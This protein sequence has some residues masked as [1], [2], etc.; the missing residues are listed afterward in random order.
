MNKPANPSINQTHL[1]LLFLLPFLFQV[2]ISKAQV[3]ASPTLRDGSEAV[4]DLTKTLQPNQVNYL[5]KRI[6]SL[7]AL[8]GSRIFI[9]MIYSTNRETLESYS[10]NLANDL[11]R[12]MEQPGNAVLILVAK[13]DRTMRI[14]VGKSLRWGLSN[15]KAKSIIDDQMAPP[16]KI[17]GYFVGINQGLSEVIGVLKSHKGKQANSWMFVLFLPLF[18]VLEVLKRF[19]SRRGLLVLVGTLAY[20]GLGWYLINMTIGLAIMLFG[21]VIS[22][23]AFKFP[24][25]RLVPK[26]I[27]KQESTVGQQAVVVLGF[28]GLMFTK[29][30]IGSGQ[31]WFG[32][33]SG[34]SGGGWGGDAGSG[35]SGGSSGGFGGDGASGGW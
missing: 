6:D 2:T 19:V 4:V 15:R 16:F 26:K 10:L 21:F 28:M 7:Y 24:K 31:G 12:G 22:F 1:L 34:S 33:S 11:S 27:D 8:T 9:R 30:S 3:Q 25:Y 14:E 13:K 23:V 17:G 32:G 35:S 29:E 18:L 20:L 5:T